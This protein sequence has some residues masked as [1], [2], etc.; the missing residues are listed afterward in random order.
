M[1]HPAHYFGSSPRVRGTEWRVSQGYGPERFI[2]A[3]AGNRQPKT[4]PF[5]LPS[6]HPRVCGEQEGIG[7]SRVS[8]GGSS[9]RVRGTGSHFF[10]VVPCFRFIPA[11]AGNSWPAMQTPTE[12][13]VHPRVCGEQ[14]WKRSRSA[15]GRGSSP[16][17]RG[18]AFCASVNFMIFRF[19]PACAGNRRRF[20]RR[21]RISPVHP[22]VCGE[23]ANHPGQL[24]QVYGSSPRV[25]GTDPTQR[26]HK[27]SNRFIPACAGNSI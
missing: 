18:T 23:Q 14:S 16:R 13:P 11:C 7:D 9:P 3:C 2:P 6:V 12:R 24:G 15:A 8:Q 4:E 25:R 27:R 17:V 22:R 5:A 20:E 19:I 10:F 1:G 26:Q 21:Q